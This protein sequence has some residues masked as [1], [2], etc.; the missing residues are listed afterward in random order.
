MTE[1]IW[2]DCREKADGIIGDLIDE[3]YS[4]QDIMFI[5]T[6]LLQAGIHV[7]T[8]EAIRFEVEEE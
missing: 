4:G 3:G 7:T 5:S 8:N 1:Y 6:Q 2:D